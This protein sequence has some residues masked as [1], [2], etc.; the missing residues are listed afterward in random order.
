MSNA[1]AMQDYPG[2][3]TIQMIKF[4]TYPLLSPIPFRQIKSPH[5][6]GISYGAVGLRHGFFTC[7]KEILSFQYESLVFLCK[8]KWE[9]QT[10]KQHWIL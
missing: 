9:E 7:K 10:A 4:I 2:H 6:S 5:I 1:L 8:V 3:I